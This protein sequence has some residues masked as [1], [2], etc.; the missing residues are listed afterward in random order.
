[1]QKLWIWAIDDKLDEKIIETFQEKVRAALAEWN[2]HQNP[3]SNKV[4]IYS[5]RFLIIEALSEVSGCSIDWLTR[6]IQTTAQEMNI[7]LAD[8]AS[9]FYKDNNGEIQKS[10]FSQIPKLLE[11]G[12]LTPETII[13]DLTVAHTNQL[14]N[15]E[16]PLKATWMNRYLKI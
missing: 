1:M 10:H 3:V 11:E 7:P 4:S 13:Y 12:I 16:A 6:N 14:E 2:A 8:S 5:K 9:V 15:F